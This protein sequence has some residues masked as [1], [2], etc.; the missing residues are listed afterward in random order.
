MTWKLVNIAVE[1]GGPVYGVAQPQETA[2]VS[3][4]KWENKAPAYAFIRKIPPKG[5]TVIGKQTRGEY[6]VK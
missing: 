5:E 6:H 1:C 4:R 2:Y 3:W